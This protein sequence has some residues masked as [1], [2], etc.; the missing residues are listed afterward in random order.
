MGAPMNPLTGTST[1]AA[2][3]AEDV[4]WIWKDKGNGTL[5]LYAGDN[6]EA[7]FYFDE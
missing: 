6:S 1:I 7:L 4:A 3:A 5:A 2:V